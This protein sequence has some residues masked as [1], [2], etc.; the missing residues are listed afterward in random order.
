MRDSTLGGVSAPETS[1][2]L[3][4]EF[5]IALWLLRFLCHWRAINYWDLVGLRERR[6]FGSLMSIGSFAECPLPGTGILSL[7]G[8]P[9]SNRRDSVFFGDAQEW[10]FP[11]FLV[12]LFVVIC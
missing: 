1:D 7:Y 8:L 6:L 10:L 3:T 4:F 2:W 5:R 11:N 12:E 9:E